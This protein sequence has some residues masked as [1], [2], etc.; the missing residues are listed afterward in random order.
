MFR[1][2]VV[3]R[4]VSEVEATV[5]RALLEAH[6]IVTL[7]TSSGPVTVLPMAVNT[8]GGVEISVDQD[9]AA[10]AARLIEEHRSERG[11]ATVVPWVD[12]LT[13]LEER[14]GHRFANRALLV[15]ALTHRSRAAERAGSGEADNEALEF[16]GDAVLGLVVAEWLYREFPSAREGT[17]SKLKAALVSAPTLAG[18]AHDLGLGAHLRLGRGEEKTGGREKENVL[19]DACEALIAALYLDGGLEVARTVVTRHLAPVL[20][21]LRRPGRLNALTGDYKSALQER[22]QARG[23]PPPTY[24]VTA[25]EGPDHARRFTVEVRSGSTLL[26]TAEGRSKKDAEQRAARI[27]LRQVDGADRED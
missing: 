3:L 20:E 26:A 7:V 12:D 18:M 22:L 5:V 9:D 24:R 1:P 4:T 15:R 16:L 23:E 13:P 8:M 27:A 21:R 6:G 11:P 10:R 2:V 25:T 14:L 19:A 17:T